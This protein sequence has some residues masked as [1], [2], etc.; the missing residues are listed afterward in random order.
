MSETAATLSPKL[1][2]VPPHRKQEAAT[3]DQLRSR[4]RALTVHRA[5]LGRLPTGA[6]VESYLG[7]PAVSL[8]L[9]AVQV[10][11][12]VEANLREV[13]AAMRAA[14]QPT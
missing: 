8:M 11:A 13:E 1:G 7:T 14:E 6:Q 10:L 4:H 9:P 5:A 12:A 2:N 3:P